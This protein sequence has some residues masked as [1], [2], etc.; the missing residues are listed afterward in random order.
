MTKNSRRDFLKSAATGAAALTGFSQIP[1]FF[2]ASARADTGLDRLRLGVIGCGGQ[3]RCDLEYFDRL[4]DTVVLCDVDSNYGL[5]KTLAT[6]LGIHRGETVTPPETCSDYRRVLDRDDLDAVLIATPDHWHTKIAIEAMQAGKHVFCEKPLTLT[7]E[8]N[9]IIRRAVEKY[10]KV[11]EVGTMQRC[12]KNQFMLA[13]L[14][15]RGGHLGEIKK[16]TADVGGGDTS[17]VIPK[18]DPPTTLD[19]N[20]WLGQAPQCDYLGGNA[21]GSAPWDPNCSEMA[22]HS[23]AHYQFRWWY[24]Y[25]GGKFTDWGAHHIDVALWCTNRQTPGTGPVSIDGTDA[26]HPVPYKDGYATV[27]NQ[28]NTA[29]KFNIYHTFSD[30]MVMNVCSQSKDGNGV[31][32]EG[33]K[34]KMHVSRGRCKG[35]I[36]EDGIADTFSEDDYVA[37]NNGAPLEA[38]PDQRTDQDRAFY[39]HKE[40]FINAIRTGAKPISDVASHVQAAHLCHLSAIAARLGR[41]IEWD[42]TN[43]KIVGDEQAA[44][45]FSRP[46]RSGFELPQI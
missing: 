10:G 23:R 20:T 13:A 39:V 43:E 16:I 35:K 41:K 6:G 18:A 5:A 37:L 4:L 27:D 40:N 29:T 24:E 30:G 33:T 15:V 38:N 8:E 9:L 19:W 1:Y 44:G 28:Y 14:I 26:E 45:F 2:S 7:L 25:S 21:D 12:F 42:S 34:G 11:F 32:F 22:P 31:L 3:G 46:Q 17:P 36:I